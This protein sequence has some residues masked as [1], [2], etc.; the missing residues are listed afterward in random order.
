MYKAS[1]GYIFYDNLG[2]IGDNEAYRYYWQQTGE[3]AKLHFS[4]LNLLNQ[5]DT[6][7]ISNLNAMANAERAKELKLLTKYFG[8]SSDNRWEKETD[9]GRIIPAMNKVLNIE[10]SFDRLVARL[11]AWKSGE[12]NAI[13]SRGTNIA[14]LFGPK[15][16]ARLNTEIPNFFNSEMNTLFNVANGPA[17]VAAKFKAMVKKTMDEELDKLMSMRAEVV[18]NEEH[19]WLGAIEAMN[20]I[21]GF[22]SDFQADFFSR[23]GFSDLESVIQSATRDMGTFE[24]TRQ[25][26]E[27]L[28]E[29]T[30]ELVMVKGKKKARGGIKANLGSMSIAGFV[31]EYIGQAF[32]AVG[33]TSSKANTFSA[34]KILTFRSKVSAF[35]TDVITILDADL[36]SYT[37]FNPKNIKSKETA[38]RAMM[39]FHADVLS[40]MKD[41]TVIYENTKKYNLGDNFEGFDGGTRNI[42]SIS[43][44]LNKIGYSDTDRLIGALKN[45]GAGTID[46][47]GKAELQERVSKELAMAIA[48]FLF[49]DL[50]TIGEIAAGQANAIHV[51]RLS[52]AVIPLSFFLKTI[53][54]AMSTTIRKDINKVV[55]VSFKIPGVKYTYP[56][57]DT[58]PRASKER[59]EAQRAE[60]DSNA[61]VSIDFLANF[62]DLLLSTL[63]GYKF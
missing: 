51:F 61:Q 10:A 2:E 9:Y 4:H 29:S 14:S 46:F 35:T 49:D 57:E 7:I 63:S 43:L 39:K 22:R 1:E 54:E 21:K 31:E 59:W 60:M 8:M 34:D 16:E 38:E 24:G 20:Q 15:L 28:Y 27:N 5:E 58:S 44:I 48:Y 40:G 62:K 11:R 19:I 56:Q 42:S 30:S 6:K 32:T 17:L 25:K 3:G 55:K 26:I 53:S 41:A 12:S 47:D 33:A 18:G 36:T 23:Y 37:A 52:G 13:A 50:D 45:S